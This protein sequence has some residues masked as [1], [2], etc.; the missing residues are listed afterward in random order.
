MRNLV[1]TL[2]LLTFLGEN[3]S[4]RSSEKK[5]EIPLENFQLYTF[6]LVRKQIEDRVIF[7][8]GREKKPEDLVW[9]EIYLLVD[10]ESKNAIYL[11]TF[12][13]K[14]IFEGGVFNRPENDSLIFIDE[15]E[16]IYFGSIEEDYLVFNNTFSAE[17]DD[18]NL[19]FDLNKEGILITDI[20]LD[21]EEEQ[22]DISKLFATEI[23]FGK[24][25]RTFAYGAKKNTPNYEYEIF[26]EIDKL[27]TDF[28]QLYGVTSCS[29]TEVEIQKI[30]NKD[31][32][33]FNKFTSSYTE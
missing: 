8:N 18:L 9:E 14:Y 6:Q 30:K 21:E 32:V 4:Y 26:E 17:A 22:V 33:A 2:L 29:K 24:D 15:L 3:H 20:V 31:I 5:I 27:L 10:H 23:F 1:C 28:E 13:H 12:S 16:F 25:D 11:S 7:V 19:G